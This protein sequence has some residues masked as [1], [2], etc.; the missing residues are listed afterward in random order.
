MSTTEAMNA[1]VATAM[2][3]ALDQQKRDE[4]IRRAIE[5]L[6]TPA[7]SNYGRGKSPLQD[8]FDMAVQSTAREIISEMLTTENVRDQIRTMCGKAFQAM[9]TDDG[10]LASG[11]ARAIVDAIRRTYT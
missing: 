2:M 3:Q 7:S 11:M 9:A 10:E 1:L 4:L 8:A 6:L 5:T